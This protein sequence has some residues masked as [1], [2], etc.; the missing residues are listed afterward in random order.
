MRSGTAVIAAWLAG[1]VAAPAAPPV[2][3]AELTHADPADWINSPPLTLAA[4]RGR[5]V[6]IEFWTFDCINCRR[7][8]P[9]LA[10]MQA[11][12]AGEG[13]V[14][15]GVHSPELEHERDPARVRAA[16][17]ALGVEYP[18]M[19]DNDFSCWRAFGNRYWPA[20]HLVGPEGRVEAT[21]IGELHLGEARGERFERE[22]RR[23][24]APRRAQPDR[25]R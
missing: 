13:L 17:T 10:A 15:I 20:F 2:E 23:L 3:A 24:L 1:A 14:I 19:L 25:G 5:V 6:L 9:W 7:T 8:L 12:Y 4:L 16:V 22:I 21:A 18:V 11:R